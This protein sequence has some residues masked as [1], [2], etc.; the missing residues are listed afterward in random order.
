M[1][2]SDRDEDYADTSSYAR[3]V[4]T[5]DEQVA[6]AEAFNK[7]MRPGLKK[8]EQSQAWDKILV[9]MQSV[10]KDQS[11]RKLL[12]VKRLKS[13]MK[14]MKEAKVKR[15]QV[16]GRADYARSGEEVSTS[17]RLE[18]AMERVVETEIE[19]EQAK[20]QAA[21]EDARKKQKQDKQSENNRSFA[22]PPSL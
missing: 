15:S 1:S 3:L 20:Q 9:H 2:T 12:D 21:N 6:L 4:L 11:S 10:V 19:Q 5:P 17:Q 13:K 22:P 14:Q 18:E 8:K 16:S 7:E